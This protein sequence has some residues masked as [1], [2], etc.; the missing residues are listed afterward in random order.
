MKIYKAD[1]SLFAEVT[2]TDDSYIFNALCDDEY[3]QVE[4]YLTELVDVPLG[5]NI[6]I[7]GKTYTMYTLPKVCKI[8]SVGYLYTLRFDY[9]EYAKMK[10]YIFHNDVDGRISFPLTAKPAEHLA[11][12]ITNLNERYGNNA[13]G[14]PYWRVENCIDSTEITITYDSLTCWDALQLLAAECGTEYEVERKVVSEVDNGAIVT[15]DIYYAVTLNK[16]EKNIDTPLRMSYGKGNGFKSEV[17]RYSD[18]DNIPIGGLYVKGSN[19]NIDASKYGAS[20]LLLPNQSSILFD[21]DKFQDESGYATVNGK[22]YLISATRNRIQR[23]KNTNIGEVAIDCTD[24]YPQRTG[25]VTAITGTPSSNTSVYAIVDSTIPDN[26]NYKESVISG[27]DMTIVFQSGMLAGKEFRV[28]QYTHTTRKFTIEKQSID[29]IMM[30]GNNFI[31]AVGDKYII[32]GITVPDEY[33][34]SAEREMLRKALKELIRLEIPQY[35]YRGQVDELWVS[36][37]NATDSGKLQCGGYIRFSDLDDSNTLLRIEAIKRYINNNNRIELT[38]GNKPL[39]RRNS[40]ISLVSLSNSL[41]ALESDNAQKRI[42]ASIVASVSGTNNTAVLALRGS[43]TDTPTDITIYGTRAYAQQYSKEVIGGFSK[44]DA[45]VT[46][47]GLNT[48]LSKF[49]VASPQRPINFWFYAGRTLNKATSTN[50]NFVPTDDFESRFADVISQANDYESKLPNDTDPLDYF[51]LSDG[52]SDK[53]IA[54]AK[55]FPGAVILIDYVGKN[56]NSAFGES[57]STG[58]MV[59]SNGDKWLKISNSGGFN[60]VVPTDE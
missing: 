57:V 43:T 55:R 2:V 17:V 24:I 14:K 15:T 20:S 30:P 35:S 54:N 50:V 9:A 23:A 37:L 41:T 22:T 32:Y 53:T 6:S 16:I 19:R 13:Y 59:V 56:Y 1:N 28:Q 46:N 27:Q 44:G 26:L 40:V 34:K 8:N 52:T 38:F 11:M 4:F 47:K 3:A 21:G 7:N 45:I 5:A 10:L 18:T 39:R 48:R 25:N 36:G 51:I 29:G 12:L 42:T 33:I 58:N 60:A 49:E 31:P